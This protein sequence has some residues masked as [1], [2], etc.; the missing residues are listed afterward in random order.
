M[1]Q[2]ER[3]QIQ[4]T[5]DL[6]QE[7]V[8][9]IEKL[10]QNGQLDEV[11]LLLADCQDCAIAIGTNMEKLYRTELETIR[12]LERF[13]EV[14]YELS[15]HL[16][17][18]LAFEKQRELLSILKE[19]K[20]ILPRELKKEVVFLP[21]KASMWDSLESVWMAAK[22][23]EECVAR[24]IP[25]P[26]F[27]KEPSGAVKEMYWEG[28]QFPSY[29]PITHYDAYDIEEHHPDMVFIHNPYDE[30]NMVTSI[31]PNYYASKLK[32]QTEKLIYIPYFI[33]D[34]A[35]PDDTAYVESKKHYVLTPGVIH[36]DKVVVQSEDMRQIYINVLTEEAG[37]ETRKHWEEKILGL[38]SPKM[39]KALNT[40]KADVEVPDEWLQVIQKADGSWKKIIFYNISL[41]ALLNYGEKMIDKIERVLD[42]FKENKEEVALLWRPHPLYKSTLE[43]MRP[44]Y[45][46][47]YQAIVDK[48]REEGWGIYDDTPDMNRAVVLSDAYYGDHSSVARL[49]KQ[50]GKLIMY[51]DPEVE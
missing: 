48:Y 22:D 21:Y 6:M 47:R 4:Q 28:E 35:K 1:G 10:L 45:S 39:D 14:L 2:I 30:G 17:E 7:A 25:I 26:Y 32:D 31:H 33:L 46:D 15:M 44:E 34:E 11:P 23:D 12:S 18:E 43:A 50:V 49:Y 36:A 3:N 19:I 5:I 20:K 42:T 29:V 51:Q 13:C 8:R 37:E 41:G 40:S 27:D 38:G 9:V 24:V 16:T